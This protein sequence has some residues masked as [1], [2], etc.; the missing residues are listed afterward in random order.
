VARRRG[1]DRMRR[2]VDK[3]MFNPIG[4]A[5]L[6][7]FG[8]PAG[9]SSDKAPQICLHHRA[10]AGRSS[11]LRPP[12]PSVT[13]H[14]H[15]IV[16]TRLIGRFLSCRLLPVTVQSFFLETPHSNNPCRETLRSQCLTHAAETSDPSGSSEAIGKGTSA[17]QPSL[18]T[19]STLLPGPA[20]YRGM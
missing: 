8:N 14:A 4:G 2:S 11:K 17:P 20:C 13:G 9:G 6:D 7:A 16:S 10:S 3:N 5:I 1:I 12:L 19:L 18:C 15:P